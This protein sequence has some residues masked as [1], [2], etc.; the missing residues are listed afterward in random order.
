MSQE[1]DGY[2]EDQCYAAACEAEAEQEYQNY[3]EK[4]ISEKKYTL[5]AAEVA[6]DWLRS[7]DRAKSK[8]SDV[9]F[10]HHKRQEIVAK[11]N[12]DNNSF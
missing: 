5:Y 6:I 7:E 10:L 1:Y 2:Y 9:E 3:L 12:N 8:F 4:L 11:H